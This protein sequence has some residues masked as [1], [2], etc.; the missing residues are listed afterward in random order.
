VVELTHTGSNPRFDIDIVFMA[1]YFFSER[2]R[3]RRQRDA[4]GDRLHES[5]DQATQS[6]EGAHRGT[7]CVRIFIGVSVHTC[8]STYIYSVFLKKDCLTLVR[9]IE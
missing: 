3:P 5:Q 6:F 1:N 4:L 9:A 7:V 8:M 2:R